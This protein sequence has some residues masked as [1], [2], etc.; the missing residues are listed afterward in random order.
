MRTLCLLLVTGTLIVSSGALGQAVAQPAGAPSEKPR[1]LTVAPDAPKQ[2]AEPASN[3]AQLQSSGQPANICAELVTF[4]RE[5]NQPKNQSPA[6]P[7]GEAAGAP[8]DASD[9]S[10]NAPERSGLPAPIPP[11]DQSSQGGQFTVQ[12]AQALLQAGD[13]PGCQRA[14]QQMRRA[15]ASLPPGL[16]ALGA[17]RRDL[18]GQAS[19]MRTGTGA[20]PD[21]L[22]Q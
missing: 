13:L 4:L 20:R 18:L 3:P 7:S 10:D 5:A 2:T 19:G 17:L 21:A 14:V 22:P 9:K 1:E 15:G 11:Q 6:K 8:K 16:L 12:Q